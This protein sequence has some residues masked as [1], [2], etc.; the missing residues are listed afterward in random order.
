MII[1]PREQAYTDARIDEKGE[2]SKMEQSVM[3]AATALYSL[4][5]FRRRIFLSLAL[6]ILVSSFLKLENVADG[7][8]APHLIHKQSTE[9]F[10]AHLVG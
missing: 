8:I 6:S 4:E 5:I 9:A 3:Q 10:S 1:D 2:M 7:H